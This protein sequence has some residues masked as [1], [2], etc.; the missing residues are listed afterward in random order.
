MEWRG[1][2]GGKMTKTQNKENLYTH[3]PNT[4]MELKWINSYLE[5]ITNI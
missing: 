2:V 5:A 1:E 4:Y 3:T